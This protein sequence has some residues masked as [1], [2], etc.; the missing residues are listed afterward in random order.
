MSTATPGDT[1]SADDERRTMALLDRWVAGEGEALTEL[2]RMHVPWLRR[3]VSRRMNAKL[4][5]HDTSEDVVQSVML[6]LLRFGPT[7]RPANAEQFRGLICRSVYNRIC[8]LADY[9][10]RQARDPGREQPLPSQPDQFY[11]SIPSNHEPGRQ[12]SAREE[13]DMII[14][15]LDL[16]DPEDKRLIAWHDFDHLGFAEIG[17]RLSLSEEGARSRHRRALGKLKQMMQRLREGRLD[18]LI[19]DVRT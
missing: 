18:D 16:I 4:R 9:A 2:V 10:G 6:N 11:V 5:K 17:E 13:R 8:E 14:M 15:A 19:D 7:F 12:V 1:P 3:Y